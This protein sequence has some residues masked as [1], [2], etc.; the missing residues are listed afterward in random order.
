MNQNTEDHLPHFR[1]RPRFQIETTFSIEELT[2]KIQSGLD[3]E[4][5]PCLGQVSPMF[6]TIY[7]PQEDQHY[8]SPQ[9]SLNFEETETGI[10]MRGFYAPRP[11]VWT[12]F[13]FF[14]AV[15]GIAILFILIFGFSYRSLGNSGAILWLIPVLVIIFFSL[16]AVAFTGQKV[17]HDQ[18]VTLHRF[19]E[20]CTGLEIIG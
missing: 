4:N 11:A 10:F 18:M 1:V 3:K 6:A 8:W 9:L 13:I 19:I 5:A 17:G 16:Y 7:I 12:M 2:E 15:I 14:Y 20:D